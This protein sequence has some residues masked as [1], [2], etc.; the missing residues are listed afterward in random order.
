MASKKKGKRMK[1]DK[2]KT[3]VYLPVDLVKEVISVSGSLGV[4]MSK[5]L[6]GAW[7]IARE[8]KGKHIPGTLFPLPTG[9]I[10]V[11]EKD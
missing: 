3:S 9:V 5:L 8:Y 6:Q 1:V 4:S 11:K 10:D 2:R 7:I